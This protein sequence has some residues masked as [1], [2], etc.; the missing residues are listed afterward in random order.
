MDFLINTVKTPVYI[1]NEDQFTS[2][3]K[4]LESAFKKYYENFKIGYSFKTNY[5]PRACAIIKELGGYAEVVS[6]MELQLAC[7]LGFKL[8]DIIYNGVCKD[9]NDKFIYEFIWNDGMLNVDNIEEF[10]KIACFAEQTNIPVRVGIR[11]NFDIGNDLVSRFGIDVNGKDFDEVCETVKNNPYIKI[12]GIHCHISKARELNYWER[13]VD[14]MI[15]ISKIFGGV[16]YIDLGSNLYSEMEEEL[17]KQYGNDI[18]TFEQYAETIAKRFAEEFNGTYKPTL[19]LETGTPLAANSMSVVSTVRNIKEVQGKTFAT[20]D[21]SKYNL[22]CISEVKDVPIEVY[23]LGEGK[24]HDSVDLVGYTC[25]ED[26]TVKRNY[27]GKIG[28]G[29]K[30]LFKNVGAYSNTMA[31][32]FIK[33]NIPIVN[34]YGD[35]LKEG[36]TYKSVFSKYIY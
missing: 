3:F 24:E 21:C 5:L 23:N 9:Y 7:D 2:N 13:R 34:E 31:N 6:P 22:G 30:V 4:K 14:I 15:Y 18:P 17:A 11:L 29:D 19:I 20:M 35:L 25:I 36:D 32:H 26:D 27:K 12:K 16:D 10:R 33:P 8:Q 28:V 1:F